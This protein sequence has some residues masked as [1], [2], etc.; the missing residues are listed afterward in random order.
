MSRKERKTELLK[1]YRFIC[2]CEACVNNYPL[3][4]ELP[5]ID[6]SRYGMID[7][8]S[9]H[10]E[11]V[12]HQKEKAAE[13]LPKLRRYLNDIGDQYPRSETCSCQE[14]FLRAFQILHMPTSESAEY[15]KYCNP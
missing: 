12:L 1:Q 13:L 8:Q 7:T 3:Y 2:E 5:A 4:F 9:L 10:A 14:L 6:S 15:Y 11:L